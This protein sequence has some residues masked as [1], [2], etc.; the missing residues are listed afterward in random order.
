MENH[1][2]PLAIRLQFEFAGR[3]S[4]IVGL[5]W[6]WVD[7]DN[8]RV[9]WPDSKTGGMFNPMSEEAYRLLSTDQDRKVTPMYCRLRAIGDST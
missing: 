6:D 4:E 8:R 7:L 1:V 9:V 2:I 5:Q 3:C